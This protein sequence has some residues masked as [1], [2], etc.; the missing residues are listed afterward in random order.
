MTLPRDFDPTTPA[1]NFD[2]AEWAALVRQLDAVW[3]L[4]EHRQFRSY[5]L[6]LN[7]CGRQSGLA[8]DSRIDRA[9]SMLE[10]RRRLLNAQQDLEAFR[11]EELAWL[12][13]TGRPVP[14]GPDGLPDIFASLETTLDLLNAL[15][16][17]ARNRAAAQTN[18]AD[19]LPAQT[20]PPPT[21]SGPLVPPVAPSSQLSGPHETAGPDES[22]GERR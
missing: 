17:A 20:P 3:T 2:D 10:G 15:L 22:Q 12:E 6:F 11:R 16:T 4:K 5:L 9:L 13:S 19:D 18:P 1:R 21:H 7:E 14:A 8:N